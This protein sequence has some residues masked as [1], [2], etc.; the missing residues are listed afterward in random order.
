MRNTRQKKLIYD[1]IVNSYTHP[2]ALQ[3]YKEA[4][5]VIPDISLG[6]V[7]RNLNMLVDNDSIVRIKMPD[8]IDRY[9]KCLEH[10]HIICS[11][12]GHIEDY[13]D[14]SIRFNNLNGFSITGYNLKFYGKC[15]DCIK[16]GKMNMELK[17]SK[18]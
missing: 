18:T 1:I 10:A 13:F 5:N 6:T 2:T 3:I 16:K 8:G 14:Y 17:G 7:Y 15:N 9:D 4:I 11:N 12:C